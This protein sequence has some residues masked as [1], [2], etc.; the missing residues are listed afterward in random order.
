[1]KRGAF[2]RPNCGDDVSSARTGG[3]S[4]LGTEGIAGISAPGVIDHVP[5]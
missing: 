2:R 3:A 4:A 1:M 5:G